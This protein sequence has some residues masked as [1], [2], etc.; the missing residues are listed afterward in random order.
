MDLLTFV[1]V[2]GKHLRD[3]GPKKKKETSF[4]SVCVLCTWHDAAP[5]FIFRQDEFS[6]PRAGSRAQKA[7]VI[8]Y[9]HQTACHCV[10]GSTELH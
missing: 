8:S 7:N 5:W 1:M 9:F 4:S 3:S 6:Q 10:H 2:L